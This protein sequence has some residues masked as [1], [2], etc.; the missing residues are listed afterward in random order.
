MVAV[1][2]GAQLWRVDGVQ[3][4]AAFAQGCVTLGVEGLCWRAADGQKTRCSPLAV[5][6]SARLAVGADGRIYV[7]T[8][9]GELVV[10]ASTG[11]VE[12]VVPVARQALWEPVVDQLRGQVL[13]AA[14][15]GVVGAVALEVGSSK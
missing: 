7:P 3:S 15:D 4:L 2:D 8:T 6:A 10:V 9:R 13:A 12:R 1:R 14:G 5:Q 11:K